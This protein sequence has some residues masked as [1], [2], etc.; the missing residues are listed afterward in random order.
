[1]R[2]VDLVF[3]EKIINT[4]VVWVWREIPGTT[5][6]IEQPIE[7]IFTERKEEL[8]ET[9]G[10][11]FI[12]KGSKVYLRLKREPE[13]RQVLFEVPQHKRKD[14]KVV[15]HMNE[16]EG[17]IYPDMKDWIGLDS[18]TFPT[19]EHFFSGKTQGTLIGKVVNLIL[20]LKVVHSNY[21][22]AFL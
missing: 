22:V 12:I 11:D 14:W 17:F 1:M 9:R 8:R 21:K 3:R 19:K 5:F 15:V 6:L 10:E 4:V 16:L 2:E 13:I 20:N 18:P 7:K